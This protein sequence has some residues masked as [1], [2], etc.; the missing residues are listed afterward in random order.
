MGTFRQ[1]DQIIYWKKVPGTFGYYYHYELSRQ[2][3]KR[4]HKINL[5]VNNFPGDCFFYNN[6]KIIDEI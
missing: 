3:K 4:G 6:G 5:P 2:L 1:G